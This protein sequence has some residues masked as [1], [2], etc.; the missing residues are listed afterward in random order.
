MSLVE[1]NVDKGEGGYDENNNNNAEEGQ[2]GNSDYGNNIN[3][4]ELSDIQDRGGE[5]NN[6]QQHS[7]KTKDK[8]KEKQEQLQQVKR[9]QVDGKEKEPFQYPFAGNPPFPVGAL[10]ALDKKLNHVRWVVPV[11]ARDDLEQLLNAAIN[12][13]HE[14]VPI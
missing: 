6:N 1:D 12:L 7:D 14:G 9:M 4:M 8:S 11:L 5:C 10:D 3:N 2:Y 13:C